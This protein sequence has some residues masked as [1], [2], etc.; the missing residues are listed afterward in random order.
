MMSTGNS[1]KLHVVRGDEQVDLTVPI[2][3]P[4]NDPQR[5]SDLGDPSKGLI[6]E[7]GIVGATI[8]P[9][10]LDVL[11]ELRI[12]SGVLVASIVD[13]SQAVD[14]GLMEG[15]VIH[16]LNRTRI[17]NVDSLR[18]A[19]NNLKPGEPAAMQVERDGKLTYVTFDME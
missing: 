3:E 5:L 2:F 9:E 18:A 17:T 19:L 12:F 8:S 11:R 14:S 13:G 10:V 7:L 15:D 4:K 1:A 6:P 16:T